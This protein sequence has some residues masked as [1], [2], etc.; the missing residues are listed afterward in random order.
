V[1]CRVSQSGFSL[2]LNQMTGARISTEVQ[3]KVLDAALKIA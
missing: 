2:V 1:H 3:L